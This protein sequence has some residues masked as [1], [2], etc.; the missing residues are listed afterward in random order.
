VQRSL[1]NHLWKL[2]R[3]NVREEER[4]RKKGRGIGGKKTFVFE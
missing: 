4:E 1:K 2:E 3:F